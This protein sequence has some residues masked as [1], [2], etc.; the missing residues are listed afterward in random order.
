MQEIN[1]IINTKEVVVLEI[2]RFGGRNPGFW[3][4]RLATSPDSVIIGLCYIRWSHIAI[5]VFGSTDI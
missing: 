3:C 4:E 1:F 2:R 5:W